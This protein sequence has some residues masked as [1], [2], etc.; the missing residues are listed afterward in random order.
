[1]S[2]VKATRAVTRLKGI[3]YDVYVKIRDA[4]GND[5]LRMAYHDGVLE[6]MSPEFRHDRA[7]RRL[8]L[9]VYAY[10]KVFE[11]PCEPAG[12]TTF[13]KG[14]PGQLKGKGKEA[15][16]SFYIGAA[17]VDAIGDKESLDLTVDPPPSLWVEIDN[18][19]SSLASLPLYAGLGVPEVWRYRPRKRTLWFGRLTGEEYREV[20][21]SAALPGLT[22]TTVLDLLDEVRTRK[23]TAWSTWLETVWFPAHRQEL[24]ARGAGGPS[25]H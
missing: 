24:I 14:L 17:A 16:E 15:D 9:L 7:G 23:S 5:G 12:S 3:T 25:L 11:V 1:M 21:E 6:I 10:C 18:R 4:R 22:I 2:T 8:L 13:H 19:G 20:A